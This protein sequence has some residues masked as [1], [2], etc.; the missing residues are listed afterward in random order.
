MTRRKSPQPAR[1]GGYK[2]LPHCVVDSPAYQDLPH[3]AIALLTHLMRCENGHN[4]GKLVLSI[5]DASKRMKCSPTTAGEAF[6]D[7]VEHG[8]ITLRSPHV[9]T[10]QI[11][12]EW[13]ITFYGCGG[14]APTDLWRQW[15]PGQ[16]VDH[17]A[18]MRP[19]D[20]RDSKGP[21]PKLHPRTQNLAQVVPESGTPPVPESGTPPKFS[22]I[23]NGR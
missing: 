7:L 16:P 14:K 4:N 17:L 3:R 18:T 23:S 13:E 15:A 12:R 1:L 11:A 10:Q 9:Y 2:Q 5:R 19:R 21:P 6:A 20:K 22:R 8:F